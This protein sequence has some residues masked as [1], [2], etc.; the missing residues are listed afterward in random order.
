MQKWYK[1][2]T[3]ELYIQIL[4]QLKCKDTIV[5][6]LE[7]LTNST[8]IVGSTNQEGEAEHT[9]NLYSLYMLKLL[10]DILIINNNYG[11]YYGKD[12]SELISEKHK[13]LLISCVQEASHWGLQQCLHESFYTGNSGIFMRFLFEDG[14]LDAKRKKLLFWIEGFASFIFIRP[15]H[16]RN[17]LEQPMIHFIAAIVTAE[18]FNA[19]EEYSTKSNNLTHH[20]NAYLQRI[21][22]NLSKINFFRD[23]ILLKSNMYL[24]E[25]GQKMLHRQLLLRLWSPGGFISLLSTIMKFDE[26]KNTA[27][28]EELER[29]QKAFIFPSSLDKKEI[30][31]KIVVQPT[32]S[33]KAKQSLMKQ[34]LQFLPNCLNS[35][36]WNEDYMG[37][38]LLCLRKYFDLSKDC[39]QFVE[40]WLL[41]ELNLLINPRDTDLIVMEW[42]TFLKLIN[43]LFHIFTLSSIECLPTDLLVPY[44]NFFL[45]LSNKILEQSTQHE[46]LIK[47]LHRLIVKCLH[48]RN[49]KELE[50]IIENW[51][52]NKCPKNWHRL[53]NDIQFTR[54]PLCA[55]ELRITMK[56]K[57]AEFTSRPES[58]GDNEIFLKEQHPLSAIVAILKDSNFNLLTFKSF[59]ILFRLMPRIINGNS[60]NEKNIIT[61]GGASNKDLLQNTNEIHLVVFEEI[62]E[63]FQGRLQAFRALESLIQFEPMKPFINENISDFLIVLK[64]ILDIFQMDRADESIEETRSSM[65]LLTIIIIREIIENS[66]LEM[67]DNISKSLL[68]PLQAIHAKLT[69]TNLK[70][71]IQFILQILQT[72]Y[73]QRYL[74]FYRS[75]RNCFEEA[76]SLIE[77]KE[78]YKQVEGLECLIKLIRN[79]DSYTLNNCHI[80]MA[81]AFETLKSPDSYT[82]LNCIRLFVALVRV[83]ETDVLEMLKDEY[84]NE[85]AAIDYRLLI[86][87]VILKIGRELG[88]QVFVICPIT[89]S[90]EIQL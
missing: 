37:I 22:L 25:S 51:I 26:E 28:I 59:K 74:N 12:A 83:H 70:N 50:N 77:S 49:S 48:N 89:I 82:F 10:V 45:E 5:H 46:V 60:R 47:Q 40:Q 4:D 9:I 63:H 13:T 18:V 20:L 86:G 66:T 65:L 90:K 55:E 84:V 87:E 64:E 85:T 30:L 42:C 31:M 69:D 38:A 43:L 27:R 80:I 67:G 72:D 11:N 8:I 68:Q 39:R 76:R 14:E 7:E 15:L 16:I 3:A 21:W 53:H 44:L 71:Q 58:I 32:Y 57:M 19:N 41:T 73:R 35:H 81:L 23:L 52:W 78:P 79:Q 56:S 36:V 29:E 2:N 34:I 24:P 33:L 62:R 6:C 75:E 54:N 17:A 88:K 1:L 61:S